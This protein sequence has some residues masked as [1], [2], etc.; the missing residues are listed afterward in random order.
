MGIIH[1]PR[2]G[3]HKV[4]VFSLHKK[5]ET[6]KQKKRKSTLSICNLMFQGVR[7][8]FMHHWSSMWYLQLHVFALCLLWFSWPCKHRFIPFICRNYSLHKLTPP[9]TLSNSLTST[10]PAPM[11]WWNYIL[12]KSRNVVPEVQGDLLH[13]V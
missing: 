1:V 6:N 13:F 12:C 8:R 9:S 2:P 3:I 10:P 11:F 7:L 4:H 5:T